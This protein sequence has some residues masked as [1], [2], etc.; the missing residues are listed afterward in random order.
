MTNDDD[1]DSMQGLADSNEN[2]CGGVFILRQIIQMCIW[3][4]LA[5]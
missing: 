3:R 2:V 4:L 5:I 1:D